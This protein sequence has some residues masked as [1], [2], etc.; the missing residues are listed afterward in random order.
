MAAPDKVTSIPVH[1]STLRTLRRAKMAD[2]TWDAFLLALVDGYIS[3]T[4][5]ADLNRR[6]RTERVVRGTEMKTELERWRQGRRQS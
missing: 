3:P 1:Q 6:L 2:Q 4:L 5:R